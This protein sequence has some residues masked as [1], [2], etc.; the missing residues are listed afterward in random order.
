[1]Q[2]VTES[3]AR[4]P[5]D[6]F[7]QEAV[8]TET[9]VTESPARNPGDGFVQVAAAAREH[10]ES[11]EGTL[12]I[13]RSGRDDDGSKWSRSREVSTSK[14]R[15]LLQESQA[16]GTSY[17]LAIEC[18]VMEDIITTAVYDIY[19]ATL[20]TM[21]DNIPISF[22]TGFYQAIWYRCLSSNPRASPRILNTLHHGIEHKVSISRDANINYSSRYSVVTAKFI[23]L[24]N[25]AVQL[26]F[27][28]DRASRRRRPV[29]AQQS[30]LVHLQ[31]LKFASSHFN[32]KYCNIKEDIKTRVTFQQVEN[33]PR[34]TIGDGFETYGWSFT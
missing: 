5:G 30:T 27:T 26:S 22:V 7:I 28:Q 6:G 8:A 12:K 2:W 34:F 19:Q 20:G 25:F 33:Q 29:V 14:Q 16:M 31:S 32:K 15:R 3:A 11:D 23:A 17:G 24:E 9:V 21:R 18:S 1:S 4:N 13:R 10:T